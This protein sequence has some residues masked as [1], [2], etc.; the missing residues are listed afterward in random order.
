M[1]PSAPLFGNLYQRSGGFVS[2]NLLPSAARDKFFSRTCITCWIVAI[3]LTFLQNFGF[4]HMSDDS[5][6]THNIH[7]M[8]IWPK[9]EDEEKIKFQR[10]MEYVPLCVAVSCLFFYLA[11]LTKI[12]VSMFCAGCKQNAWAMNHAQIPQHL[13]SEKMRLFLICFFSY[14][15]F[16]GLLIVSI[17]AVPK[18]DPVWSQ[19]GMNVLVTL[20]SATE[21]LVL[22]A[23]SKPIRKKIPK[24]C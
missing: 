3:I 14:L 22:F 16:L 4:G 8:T 9:S 2:A 5:F 17:L 20:V 13:K 21:P 6:P 12:T 18:L 10:A 1:V 19:Y 24:C 7:K 23:M 11:A 15:P